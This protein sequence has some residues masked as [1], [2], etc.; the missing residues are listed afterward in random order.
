MYGQIGYRPPPIDSFVWPEVW[1]STIS[2]WTSAAVGITA[3]FLS[4]YHCV[5]AHA[6][7]DSLSRLPLQDSSSGECLSEVSVY[8][9][10]QI[11]VLPV[12]VVQVCKATRA[13]S[14]LSKVVHYLRSGWPVKVPDP[15]KPFFTR[16]DELSI[17]EGC[18]IWGTRVIVP[19]KLQSSVFKL[20]HEGHVGMVKMKMIA[21]S[22]IWWPCIVKEIEDSV[23][24][25]KSCQEVQTVPESAPLHPLIWPCKP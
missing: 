4:V 10:S 21:C 25:C 1:S 9:I 3:I 18:I 14:V 24:S 8:N 23:K 17:E 16:R 13:D 7:A 11:S 12:S 22:Y 19:K 20:L 5:S 6:N 2:S 15:L